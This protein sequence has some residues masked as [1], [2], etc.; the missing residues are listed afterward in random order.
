MFE[1]RRL[2]AEEMRDSML[3]ITG[4]LNCDVGGV[5]CRP[6]IN[7]EVALQPRQVMGAFAT[8]WVRIKA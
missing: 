1:P 3:A 6:E 8:A 7:E 2:S 5:P 4:E